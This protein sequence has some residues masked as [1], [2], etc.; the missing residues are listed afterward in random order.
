MDGGLPLLPP[1][2]VAKEDMI[3]AILGPAAARLEM[4]FPDHE[5][6]QEFWGQHPAFAD[7]WKQLVTDYVDYDLC[8][9]APR[10]RPCTS[11][12]AIEADSWELAGG[13]SLLGAIER[14]HHP[15]QLLRAPRGL[16]N[17]V[18]PLYPDAVVER[19]RGTL[20]TLSDLEMSVVDDVNHYT[21]VMHDRGVKHVAEAAR[22]ALTTP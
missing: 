15:A 7:D 4:I 5:V 19:W 2:G 22:R 13:E 9:E 18:P 14:L 8:G 1:P 6:Y 21:I 10:L 11:Y 20:S 16:L 12:A 17:E 3:Q